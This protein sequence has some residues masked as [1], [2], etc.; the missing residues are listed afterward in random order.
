MYGNMIT[1]T[2]PRGMGNLDLLQF[3]AHNNELVGTIPEDF[4]NNQRLID[5]RLDG[6]LFSGTISTL[7]GNLER[8]VDLRISGNLF[9]GTLPSEVGRL[10]NIRT[11][12]TLC[13]H[14]WMFVFAFWKLSILNS[15]SQRYPLPLLFHAGTLI[16]NSTSLSGPINFSFEAFRFLRY[17]DFSS[18]GFTGTL[19]STLFDIPM[20]EILY[21]SNNEFSGTIP[22]TYINAAELRELHLDGNLIT[23]TIPTFQPGQL[24][25]LTEF[26]VEGN[27]ISGSV[28]S[29]FCELGLETLTAEPILCE[30]CT[31]DIVD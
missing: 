13:S 28:P 23:G 19:P 27:P 21:F 7:I 29:A 5:L 26:R 15:A 25:A 24:A 17:A 20:I 14:L 22:A 16:M 1:G 4:W 31:S 2:I 10:S 6:N 8:L 3:Q 9:S 12:F 18:N 11:F 30:C